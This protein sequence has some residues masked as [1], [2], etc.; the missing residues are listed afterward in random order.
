M[1]E[2]VVKGNNKMWIM[3]AHKL[4]VIGGIKQMTTIYLG[5]PNTHKNIIKDDYREIMN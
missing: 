5:K 4:H 1:I 2:K 3:I